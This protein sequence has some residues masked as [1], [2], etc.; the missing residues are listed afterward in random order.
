MAKKPKPATPSDRAFEQVGSMLMALIDQAEGAHLDRLE[1]IWDA[2][3]QA[4]PPEAR[5]ALQRGG[6]GITAQ[7][8]RTRA[9]RP[10]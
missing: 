10:D 7:A 2:L 8:A 9:K 3:L 5:I 4:L 1:Q 6:L